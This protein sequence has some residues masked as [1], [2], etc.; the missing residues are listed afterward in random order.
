M[1]LGDAASAQSV[2]GDL[3]KSSEAPSNFRRD[4]N[5]SVTQR[6]HPGYEALG[7]REGAFM[8][9]PKLTATAEYNSNIFATAAG[10]VSDTI[11]HVTPEVNL[12]SNWSRHSL[13]AYARGMLNRYASNS[14]QKTDDYALGAEGQLDVLRSARIN[15]GVDLSRLT[16]PRTSAG[17]EG[18][19]FPVQYRLA[20]ARL[21]GERE[22]NR[23]RLSARADWSKF[24]YLNR[25]GN[26]PQDDRDRTVVIGAVRGDY[27]I[28]PDT[29]L[30][31]EVIAND[32]NYRLS[33]SPVVAGAPLFPNFVN[34][35]SKGAE[36]LAG[37]S[38]ELAALVRGEVGVGYLK[39]TFKDSAFPDVKGL[40]ARA[41][42][43]WF[44]TQLTTVT[45]TGSRAVEDAAVI[46]AS[47]YLSSNL[48]VQV[49]HELLRNVLLG[50]TAGYGKDDYRGVNR[51]DK[52]W[53]AGLSATYLMNRNI[54][55]TLAYNHAH[56]TSNRAAET[57]GVGNFTIDRVGAT[58]T[59]QY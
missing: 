45:F 37:A 1:N 27:A 19:A 14:D 31:V 53:S 34:R 15:G 33:R 40:G 26:V 41:Q 11:F 23:L 58:L 49:D 21:A 28:S 5:V 56:Q 7:L 54:G 35:D 29:A 38:F 16:E 44:P 32:R 30:F 9:W 36:A 10:T 6:P 42:V 2:Q 57:G 46:G 3:S 13:Q 20:T 18:S 24:N 25:T 17:S 43:E 59:L 39:Q 51:Q 55:A 22:F 4:R 52:R 47:S 12:T 8:V 48:G 50:A